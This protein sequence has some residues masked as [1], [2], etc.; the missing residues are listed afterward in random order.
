MPPAAE[1]R[2]SSISPEAPARAM[3]LFVVP[4]ST[5]MARGRP[6]RTPLA[7]INQQVECS[8]YRSALRRPLLRGGGRSRF[9]IRCIHQEVVR[10]RIERHGLRPELGLHRLHQTELVRCVLVEYVDRALAG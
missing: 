8:R 4:K 2:A 1:K 9:K 3:E 7:S 5:P 6:E 10:L